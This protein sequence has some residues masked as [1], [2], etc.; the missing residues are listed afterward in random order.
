M[1]GHL[2]AGWARVQV[3]GHLVVLR[4]FR[5]I[6]AGRLKTKNLAA[7]RQPAQVQTSAAALSI[8]RHRLVYVNLARRRRW[9]GLAAKRE[10]RKKE[11]R[12]LVNLAGC[13]EVER[14]PLQP[15]ASLDN[16]S[17]ETKNQKDQH[18][19]QGHNNFWRNHQSG[20]GEKLPE[21]LFLAY[22]PAVAEAIGFLNGTT[23]SSPTTTPQSALR[24]T[25]RL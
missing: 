25:P 5:R 6:A 4:I 18:H 9:V 17:A 24:S 8:D 12:L 20:S 23:T 11:L 1:A 14:L 22:S 19:R 2:H 15:S 10:A 3:R 7:R 16:Q 21:P 13:P